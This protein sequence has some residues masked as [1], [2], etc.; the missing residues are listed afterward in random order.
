MKIIFTRDL[1]FCEECDK[2]IKAGSRCISELYGTS[3]GTFTKHYCLKCAV[4]VLIN[5]IKQI[6]FLKD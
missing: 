6:K 3:S 4:K 5:L 1:R 2:Q